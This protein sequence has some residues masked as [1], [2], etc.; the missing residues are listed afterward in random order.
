MSP[1]PTKIEI[2]QARPDDAAACIR[3]VHRISEEFPENVTCAPGEFD[4][5]VEQEQKLLADAAASDN[6][7]FLLALADDDVVGLLNYSGGKRRSLR[8]A[9]TLGVSVRKAWCDRGVGT[10]LLNAAIA[11]ARATGVVRRI[12]LQV[13]NH[14]ERAIHVYRK[15]GFTEEGRRRHAAFKNGRYYDDLV[16]AL[17]FD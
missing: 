8:H 9:V 7:L 17:L 16:M 14:N 6:A 12:E 13:Y 1:T 2:R 5:T 10:A 4:V 3:H 11:H 15:L